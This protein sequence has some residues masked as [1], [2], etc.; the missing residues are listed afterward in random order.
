MKYR[1]ILAATSLVIVAGCASAGNTVLREETKESVSEKLA[2]GQ[3]MNEVRAMFG[4]PAST[5]YTDGGQEIWK[6]EFTDA[7]AKASSF[8]PVVSWFNSGMKGTKKELT[9]LF[10]P[11]DKVQKF[12]MN[13]S[14]VDTKTGILR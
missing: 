4:D 3:S 12:S 14:A 8:V 11:N 2:E 5:T 13:E 7:Q 6:Y 9:I 10:D 1:A